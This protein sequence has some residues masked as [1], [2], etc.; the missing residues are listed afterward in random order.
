MANR[1]NIF[2]TYITGREHILKNSR[3]SIEK[4]EYMQEQ[5]TKK[6]LSTYDKMSV[7][8]IIRIT[9]QTTLVFF[10]PVIVI[11]ISEFDNIFYYRDCKELGI[12]FIAVRV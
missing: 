3:K 9:N 10:L 7:S 6:A 11:Q 12:S 1:E 5:L 4:Q 2:S 8:T